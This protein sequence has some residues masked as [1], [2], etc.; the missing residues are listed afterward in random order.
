METSEPQMIHS[1]GPIVFMRCLCIYQIIL[2]FT[3]IQP[4]HQYF[5]NVSNILVLYEI[6]ECIYLC[7]FNTI[8][9][10]Q[11]RCLVKIHHRE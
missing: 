11:L 10:V 7:I 2:L 4:K 6:Y 3:H 5:R 8:R 9:V 1:L